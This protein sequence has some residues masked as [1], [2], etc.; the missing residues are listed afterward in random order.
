MNDCT[1]GR[2]IVHGVL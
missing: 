1:A 2:V